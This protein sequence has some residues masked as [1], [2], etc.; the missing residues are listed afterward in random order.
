MCLLSLMRAL[1]VVGRRLRTE[2]EGFLL[3]LGERKDRISVGEVDDGE[4]VWVRDSWTDRPLGDQYRGVNAVI[5]VAQEADV[6]V[7]VL[8]EVG[9]YVLTHLGRGGRDRPPSV[10]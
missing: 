9:Q 8:D 10:G 2:N 5:I 6:D 7:E 3:M 4:W 1:V